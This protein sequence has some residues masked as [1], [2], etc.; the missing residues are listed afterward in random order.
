[1]TKTKKQR[2]KVDWKQAKNN[3]IWDV[4]TRVTKKLTHTKPGFRRLNC[5]PTAAG[6]RVVGSS[7]YNKQVLGKIRDAYNRTHT[8]YQI[9]AKRPDEIYESLRKLLHEECTQEDCW[10][11]LLSEK[12]REYIAEHFFSPAHPKEWNDN[13][14]AWLSNYDIIHVLEQYE[15]AYPK[16][17]FLPPSPID[18]D[19]KMTKHR[20]V[21]NDLC[22]FQLS[23]FKEKGIEKIGIVLNL[24][25]HD[26]SGSHWVTLYIDLPHKVI[27]Y[28]DSALNETPPE[29][30]VLIKRIK[31]QGEALGISF[32]ARKNRITHQFSNTECGMY[33]LFFLVSLVTDC[34]GGEPPC[35]KKSGSKS[36]TMTFLNRFEKKRISD[37]VVAKFRERY[38]N[39][40]SAQL[41]PDG[42]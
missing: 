9:T 18:F 12:E 10:L 7:C 30:E 33:A 8:S 24:D 31:K 15:K 14:R 21:T 13:P 37:G 2:Y 1:M 36:N 40:P 26:E 6:G 27:F 39:A 38:F 17:A 42:G 22:T 41:K 34:W 28:L 35:P 11:K 4:V 3:S 32:Q 29:V 19:K 5:A 25:E 20:C 23:E 16:F